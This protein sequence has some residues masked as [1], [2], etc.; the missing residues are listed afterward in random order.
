M[1]TSSRCML[2]KMSLDHSN[3]GVVS[4][5]EDISRV[6]PLRHVEFLIGSSQGNT[7]SSLEVKTTVNIFEKLMVVKFDVVYSP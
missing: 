7:E 5:L 6:S 2:K 1:L 3:R 4:I